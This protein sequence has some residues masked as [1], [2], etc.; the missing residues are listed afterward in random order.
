MWPKASIAVR[1]CL[2]GILPV[3]AGLATLAVGCSQTGKIKMADW[4]SPPPRDEDEAFQAG[5]DLPPSP[6][7][8][9]AVAKVY[10]AQR[11]D[12]QC[13][14]LLLKI[15]AE[16]P[17]F[18]P[19]YC[20]LAE[21]QLRQRRIDEA[22][23]TLERGLRVAPRDTVLRNDLGMC[24]LMKGDYEGALKSFTIAVASAPHD[25][26]YRANMAVALGLL[27]RD[28][29]SMALYEQVLAP[30]EVASNLAI[31]RRARHNITGGTNRGNVSTQPAEN[32]ESR[33]GKGEPGWLGYP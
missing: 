10:R 16:N 15:V 13:E 8:I 25:P 19:A 6:K 4:G 28:E 18:L 24:R 9:Y 2:Y 21:V 5:A 32:G 11:R 1:L 3:T 14:S 23:K 22:Q 29:E 17:R 7:T 20:D 33:P 30:E 31:L 26:R 27:G 12:A